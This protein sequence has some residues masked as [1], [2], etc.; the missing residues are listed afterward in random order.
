MNLASFTNLLLVFL[1][2]VT[3]WN[4]DVAKA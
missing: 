1:N 4:D 3:R 2:R